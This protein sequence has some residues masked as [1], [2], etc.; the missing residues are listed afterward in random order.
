MEN[1]HMFRFRNC[2]SQHEARLCHENEAPKKAPAELHEID[3]ESDSTEKIDQLSKRLTRDDAQNLRDSLQEYDKIKY[4]H[5]KNLSTLTASKKE[6]EDDKTEAK[7]SKKEDLHMKGMELVSGQRQEIYTLAKNTE[8]PVL[9]LQII[10]QL[11]KNIEGIQGVIPELK[12][13]KKIVDKK[14]GEGKVIGKTLEK[15]EVE[16]TE[17]ADNA[18]GVIRSRHESFLADYRRET[19]KAKKIEMLKSRIEDLFSGD[20][21]AGPRGIAYEAKEYMWYGGTRHINEYLKQIRELENMKHGILPSRGGAL[22]EIETKPGEFPKELAD[23]LKQ[24][25]R[26]ENIGSARRKLEQIDAKAGGDGRVQSSFQA[27]L[28]KMLAD[29]KYRVDLKEGKLALVSRTAPATGP[30]TYPPAGPDVL[31]HLPPLPPG[32]EKPANQFLDSGSSVL[33][34]LAQIGILPPPLVTAMNAM[35]GREMQQLNKE[36]NA[37]Q[38][39]LMERQGRLNQNI[40]EEDKAKIRLEIQAITLDIN[41]RITQLNELK[42]AMSAN[43][44]SAELFTMLFKEFLK[45]QRRGQRMGVMPMLGQQGGFDL[46][47]L[48]SGGNAVIGHAHNRYGYGQGVNYYPYGQF[49]GYASPMQFPPRPGPGM[50]GSPPMGFGYGPGPVGGGVITGGFSVTEHKPSGSNSGP[51]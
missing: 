21:Q 5:K 11:A 14:D 18:L 45:F 23:G 22:P 32:M 47:G 38:Q 7:E 16:D 3:P 1:T 46:Y 49:Q 29:T 2:A 44:Q 10:S 28:N 9:S 6:W 51:R 27:E 48:N 15:Y 31:Q 8:R 4:A 42:S 19:N 30:A 41:R 25:I 17:K 13:Y 37:R 33:K 20:V 43:N 40:S 34:F 50:V 12:N 39:Q 24:D 35:Q 26:D 36:L